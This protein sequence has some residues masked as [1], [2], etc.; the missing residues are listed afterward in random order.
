MTTTKTK[1]KAKGK[2]EDNK[3]TRWSPVNL[4]VFREREESA[5]SV[6]VCECMCIFVE[7]ILA[8]RA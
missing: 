7:E 2:I 4:E 8:L 6:T 3:S 1:T 5:E